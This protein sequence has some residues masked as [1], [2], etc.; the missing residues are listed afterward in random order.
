MKFYINSLKSSEVAKLSEYQLKTA[1]SLKVIFTDNACKEIHN[2]SDG[3]VRKK[4]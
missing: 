1:G 3:I 4:G 2:L